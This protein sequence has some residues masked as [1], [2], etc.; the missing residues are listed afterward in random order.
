MLNRSKIYPS[1][2]EIP[3]VATY[4]AAPGTGGAFIFT[5]PRACK[6]VRVDY[7]ADTNGAGSSKVYLRKHVAGQTA[8]ANAAVSS[9]N[10]VDLVS[11]GIAADSTVR[12]PTNP[13]LVTTSGY[14]TL[15]EGAKL[16]LVPPA[17]WIGCVVV[18]IAMLD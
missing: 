9:T 7:V 1:T 8:A 17:N 2:P 11:G 16:A 3:V 5:A 12:V 18:W 6:V 14:T 10:I 13:T 15:A 4:A